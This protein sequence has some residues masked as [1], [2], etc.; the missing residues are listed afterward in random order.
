MSVPRVNPYNPGNPVKPVHF[1]GRTIEIAEL[2]DKLAA[3][4]NGFPA[5]IF[6]QG[7]W[8]IGKTS[9]LKKM[10]PEFS[11]HGI[12]IREDVPEGSAAT[13]IRALYP[14]I[15]QDL[16]AVT[17]IE[18]ET[19]SEIDYDQ[20]RTLRVL[21]TKLISLLWEQ[22]NQLTIV[23]LDN[24]ERAQPEFLA[25]VKD[26]F[27]RVGEDAPHFMLVF[28]GK[29]LPGAGENASDPIARFF[30]T[31]LVGPMDGAEALKAISKPIELDP[32]FRID[33]EAAQMIQD[34]AAG[35]PYFL[36]QICSH[37][38]QCASGK[39][40]IDREWLKEHWGEIEASLEDTRF[41]S[42]FVDLPKAES[43]TL[44]FGS[45]SG[46]EFPRSAVS[47]LKDSTLDS[48]LRRLTKDRGLLRSAARGVYAFYH[49][50]F[51][52][53]V[54]T[55]ANAEGI[56]VPSEQIVSL[57]DLISEGESGSLEFK[58]TLQ[59]NII[60]GKKD[61]RMSDAVLK[62]IAAF[63]NTGGG[64][65][66]IGVADDCSVAGLDRDLSLLPAKRQ[67]D[68]QFILKLQ[69]LIH[70]N[71]TPRSPNRVN[72]RIEEFATGRVC[73]VEVPAR[74]EVTYLGDKLFVRDGPRTID[75]VGEEME[76]FLRGR[77]AD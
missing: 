6:V 17:G 57:E 7:E 63:Q 13:Q 69:S 33:A 62:T 24:M 21:L 58:E 20:P 51:H 48:A 45:L 32:D 31:I 5:S 59:F 41:Q 40:K 72:V 23:V 54:L 10:H 56:E 46:V 16:K 74:A 30:E 67:N 18:I 22:E 42:E 4:K 70:D 1:A 3:A 15:L 44:M 27:Q 26:I 53:Y 76:R 77:G 49:P 43:T 73:A 35:H 29:S 2:R 66:V 14:A 11:E 61:T 68:D 75:L 12:V 8:G 28:A 64:T 50:L 36:K 65:L 34:Q 71:L 39:G 55:K 19:D 37:V 60:T 9:L 47:G 25:G 38:F 52:A